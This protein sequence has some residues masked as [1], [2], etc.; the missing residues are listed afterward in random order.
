[1]HPYLRAYMA[2]ITVPTM[3]VPFI[4][5][6]LVLQHTS[7]HPYHIEDVLIFPL[8]LVPNVWGLWNVLLLRL[9]KNRDVPTGIAGAALVLV[10][11]PAGYLLQLAVGQMVWTPT[12][13]AIGF[14]VALIGYYLLWKHV[15]AQ[16]NDLLGVG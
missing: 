10:L 7:A 2:G 16:L 13:F 5:G 14:P 15:V 9:R 4:L 8:A 11:A 3:V 6:A 1:M 12:L